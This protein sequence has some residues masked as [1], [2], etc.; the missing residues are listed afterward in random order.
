MAGGENSRSSGSSSSRSYFTR[1]ALHKYDLEQR[2]NDTAT[3]TDSGEHHTSYAHIPPRQV[4]LNEWHVPTE[5]SSKLPSSE[6]DEP[7]AL[8]GSPIY[9]TGTITSMNSGIVATRTKSGSFSANNS[10]SEA[11]LNT[12][13]NLLNHA[14]RDGGSNTG[15]NSQGM[16]SDHSSRS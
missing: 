8:P 15:K 13:L 2:P 3:S 14:V 1:K 7:P 9:T 12:P 6:S 5:S 10:N 16:S 11:N 4:R